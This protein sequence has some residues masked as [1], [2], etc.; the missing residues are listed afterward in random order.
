M[1]SAAEGL[2]RSQG[3]DLDQALWKTFRVLHETPRWRAVWP[4][5][6]VRNNQGPLV[7]KFET[8]TREAERQ[9]ELIRNLLISG[10]ID[11][12]GDVGSD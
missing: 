4:T 8:R 6:R 7:E 9:A 3:Q 1:H 2:L 5:A 11:A 10:K 12:R